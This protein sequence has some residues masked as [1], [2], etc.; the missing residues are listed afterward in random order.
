[1]VSS[2]PFI[3]RHSKTTPLTPIGTFSYAHCFGV[4]SLSTREPMTMDTVMWTASCTKL[5]TTIA[6][7]QCVERGRIALDDDTA[8]LLP[9]LAEQRILTGFDDGGKPVLTDRKKAITLR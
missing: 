8:A 9:E 3:A 7:L 5:L 4:R 6:A 2:N 1:M